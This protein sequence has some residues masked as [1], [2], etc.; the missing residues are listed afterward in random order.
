MKK[1]LVLLLP[2][3]TL[4]ACQDQVQQIAGTYS[5]KISGT[6]IV[7]GDERTLTDEMGALDIIHVDS[8][9]AMLTFNALNGP[10]YVTEAEIHG[11]N[12]ELKEYERVVTVQT[13][14]YHVTASGQGTVYDQTIL[15]HLSYEGTDFQADELTLLC[16]KN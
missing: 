5:Y 11:Q 4:V 8:T 3:L 7:D 1:I 2:L 6:A 15:I 12:I 9:T 10:A 13:T 14:D 16:K